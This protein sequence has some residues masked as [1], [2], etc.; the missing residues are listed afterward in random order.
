MELTP[1]VG[2]RQARSLV[3]MLPPIYI[4]TLMWWIPEGAKYVPGLTLSAMLLYPLLGGRFERVA[5]LQSQQKLFIIGCWAVTLT[6][7]FC[8]ALNG[9]SWTELRAYLAVALYVSLFRGISVRAT[10]FQWIAALSACGFVA[11]SGYQYFTGVPR[12]GGFVNPIPYATAVGAIMLVCLA[13]GLF[14][15]MR[16]WVRG[17]FFV[18]ALAAAVALFTTK[19]RGVILPAVFIAGGLIVAAW[20]LKSHA[21]VVLSWVA[22]F[23]AVAGLVALG[24]FFL[25]NRINQTVHEYESIMSGNYSG[26]I[27][28]RLQLWA[29][30][31][32]LVSDEPLAGY[33]DGYEDALA[34]LYAQKDIER[35]LYSF[36]ANHFHNQFV[37]TLVKK[38]FVGLFALGFLLFATFRLAVASSVGSWQRYAGLSVLLMY[39][40]ASMTDVPL[41]NAPTIFLFLA[42][43]FWTGTT[44]VS[45]SGCGTQRP[46]H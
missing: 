21:H 31:G 8:Y 43:C 9:G 5:S 29:S 7:G 14:G 13:V 1:A 4:L 44:R 41:F 27:G 23:V 18:L 45:E 12:V 24:A 26:S 39:I 34:E 28:L 32:D 36:D 42:L 30:A 10:W 20:S 3:A 40:A 11:L 38:G 2:L 16:G 6:G 46:P 22:G 33:G 37:D 17:I 35:S 25:E 15:Q 19:T